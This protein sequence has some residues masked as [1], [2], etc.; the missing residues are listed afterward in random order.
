[1]IYVFEGSAM[2]TTAAR[3][4]IA[5][6]AVIK[7]LIQVKPIVPGKIIEWGISFDGFAAA[8]PG[9]V[10]LVETDVTATVTAFVDADVSRR[11]PYVTDAVTSAT[12]F[13]LSTSGSGFN[14]SAEGTITACRDMDPAIF[15]PPTAPFVKQFPL[16]QEPTVIPNK[17]YRIRVTFGTGVNAYPYLVIEV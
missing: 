1:M 6:T 9:K 16:G 5:T 15:L 12:Y 10:E 8:L 11:G 4:S 3:A 14:A 17:F 2:Q 7:T 13:T